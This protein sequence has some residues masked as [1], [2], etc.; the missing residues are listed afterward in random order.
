[1]RARLLGE[2]NARNGGSR[3]RTGAFAFAAVAAALLFLGSGSRGGPAL[4]RK[5]G[6]PDN[7]AVA[8]GTG[9][10][11]KVVL[12]LFVMSLC[13]D[14]E[15]C[16]SHFDKL[17][18]KLHPIVHVRTEYIQKEAGGRVT[19]PHGD[20]ECDGNRFQL[21]VQEHVPPA[22]NRDWYMKFLVCLWEGDENASSNPK[23]DKCL[24][25]VGAMGPDR[26]AMTVCIRNNEGAELMKKSAAVTAAR[27]MQR[28]CTVAIEGKKR[29]IRDGGR[30]YD[31]K[32]GSGD[33]DFTRSIC[34][35]Y[36]TKAG[37]DAPAGL[38]PTV[39]ASKA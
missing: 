6:P 9:P 5:G 15:F 13:P 34:D 21:C 18:D 22:H 35:A 23:V 8:G 16:E 25:K 19:C 20:A 12:E 1:M 37:K 31:C 28:S 33:G 2:P 24:D 3:A 7:P 38:C 11:D 36:K 4:S 26:K 30:W 29:C 17:L 14:A 39:A 27:G 10:D 32:G